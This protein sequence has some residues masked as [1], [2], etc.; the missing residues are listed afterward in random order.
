MSSFCPTSFSISRWKPSRTVW[1]SGHGR[2]H[3]LRAAALGRQDVL[4]GQLDRHALVVGGG[5][6]AAAFG[7]AAVV[8][9]LATEHFGKLLQARRCCG[10]RRSRTAAADA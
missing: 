4:P 7:A 10:N 8:D 5:V 2:H 6:E 9:R 3:R 1:Q